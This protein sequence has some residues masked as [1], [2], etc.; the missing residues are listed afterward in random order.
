MAVAITSLSG[1]YTYGL[2]YLVK[3]HSLKG[4]NS[5]TYPHY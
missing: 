4:M 1:T 5:R 2:K 3:K